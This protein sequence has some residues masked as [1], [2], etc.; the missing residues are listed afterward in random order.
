MLKLEMKM[1]MNPFKFN[2]SDGKENEGIKFRF[3]DWDFTHEQTLMLKSSGEATPDLHKN[4][5]YSLQGIKDGERVECEFVPFN[6]RKQDQRDGSRDRVRDVISLR[7][8]AVRP[9][10][11]NGNTKA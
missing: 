10:S 5:L 9:L 11:T 8:H 7:L 6:E 2:G 1:S 3:R 4:V